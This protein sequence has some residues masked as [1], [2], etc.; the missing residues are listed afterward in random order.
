MV[1][2]RI[3]GVDGFSPCNDNQQGWDDFLPFVANHNAS[4][5]ILFN[6]S[7]K[8]DVSRFQWSHLIAGLFLSQ[9]GISEDF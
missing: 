7:N 2:T 1:G 8:D 5:N 9:V 4:L 6:A 3:H